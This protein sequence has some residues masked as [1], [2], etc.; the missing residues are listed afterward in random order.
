MVQPVDASVER[1]CGPLNFR[2]KRRKPIAAH[3]AGASISTLP[4]GGEDSNTLL[5]RVKSS[6]GDNVK[7][8]IDKRVEGLRTAPARAVP[9][10]DW[11]KVSGPLDSLMHRVW[12]STDPRDGRLGKEE[13]ISLIYAAVAGYEQRLWTNCVSLHCEERDPLV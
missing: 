2:E 6:E 4:L 11:L 1:A 12:F 7:S 5:K 3:P 9:C 8:A 10:Q 13:M